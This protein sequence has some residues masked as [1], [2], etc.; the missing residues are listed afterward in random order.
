M[1]TMKASE[2][3]NQKGCWSDRRRSLRGALS[4]ALGLAVGLVFFPQGQAQRLLAGQ[5][6]LLNKNPQ[7]IQASY[8]AL[9]GSSTPIWI[10]NDLGI[11]E[12]YGLKVHLIYVNSAARSMAAVFSGDLQIAQ[13]NVSSVVS[14]YARGSD[15]VVIAGGFNKINV[16]IYALP[17]I[18]E[19]ADLRGKKLGITRFG[20]LYDFAANYALKKWGLQ[21]GKDVALIQIGDIPA[22]L[23][24]MAANSIQ[25]ATLQPPSTFRAAQLGYRELM[26][27][28]KSGL[29]YQTS[30]LMTTRTMLRKSPEGVKRF[31]RAYS[32]AL[33]VFH[34]QKET[35]LSVIA[36]HLKGIDPFILEKTYEEN[37]AG[38]PEIPYVNRAGME[39]AIHLTPGIE[40]TRNIRVEDIVD[41][42]CVRELDQEGFYRTLY[43]KR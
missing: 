6:S 36:K 25:A 4:G 22:I 11:F 8:A 37:R 39:T 17:E 2:V 32:E 28:A 21:P 3:P 13:S 1:T 43:G 30:A 9:N 29:E 41:E 19:P 16:S 24:A 42:T 5:A 38:I 7:V 12:K 33:A 34:L 40:A 31:M 23:G 14:A 26:D 10:A 18:R 35:A 27:L 15:P 20:G